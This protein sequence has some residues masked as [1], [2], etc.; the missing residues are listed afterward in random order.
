[1]Y[2]DS[3]INWIVNNCWHEQ[4]GAR[5]TDAILDSSVLPVLAI[6]LVNSTIMNTHKVQLT[7]RKNKIVL[8][9]YNKKLASCD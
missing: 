8:L 4:S 5:E 3:V 7:V 2:G 9:K 6:Y 1:M